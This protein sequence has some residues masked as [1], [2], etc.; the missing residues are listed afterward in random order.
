MKKPTPRKPGLVSAT[1]SLLRSAGQLRAASRQLRAAARRQKK[2]AAAWAEVA[3]KIR[4]AVEMMRSGTPREAELMS[5]ENAWNA[6]PVARGER[7]FTYADYLELRGWEFEKFRN[8]PPISDD[9]LASIEWDELFNEMLKPCGQPE[10]LS[11]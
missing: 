7:C 4:A 5:P 3:R 11:D 9:E 8:M 6:D 10:G 1:E 2:N